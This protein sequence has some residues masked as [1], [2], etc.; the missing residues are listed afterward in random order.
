MVNFV[1]IHQPLKREEV[2]SVGG[3]LNERH[4]FIER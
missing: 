3:L 1:I 2:I 4:S